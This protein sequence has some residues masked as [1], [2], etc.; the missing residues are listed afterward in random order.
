MKILFP[1]AMLCV[2]AAPVFAQPSQDSSL[3][4]QNKALVRRF[5]E[6]VWKNGNLDVA[7][8]IFAPDY[9]RHDPRYSAPT[10]GPEGQKQIAAKF[11][12]RFS[13]LDYSIDL[14]IAE[15]D[16]VAARWTIRVM[17]KDI[18]R[19]LALG[20]PFDITGVNIF[21]FKNGKVVEIWNH[22]N[23]LEAQQNL[24]VPKLQMA[25]GFLAGVVLCTL[26]WLLTKYRR[27]KAERRKM[28]VA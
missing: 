27:K 23:D 9:A 28:A 6:E 16:L 17:P 4:E 2:L 8:E 3:Q 24:N 12:S 15:A 26:I 14:T 19:L 13:M 5:Y 10:S 22:R 21:R 18:Y 25:G 7:D 20:K 11:R 1:L